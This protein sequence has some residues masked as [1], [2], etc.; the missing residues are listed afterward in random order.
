MILFSQSIFSFTGHTP[1]TQNTILKNLFLEIQEWEKVGHNNSEKKQSRAPSAPEPK[2][3]A[4]GHLSTSHHVLPSHSTQPA[5]GFSRQ[6]STCGDRLA[7]SSPVDR[8]GLLWKGGCWQSHHLSTFHRATD[9]YRNE[10]HTFSA[11][12]WGGPGEA[13]WVVKMLPRPCPTSGS[14]WGIL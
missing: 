12:H 4:A 1:H 10:L 8:V 11:P 6:N 14:P 7:Y 3:W 2:A 5:S 13:T 9:R